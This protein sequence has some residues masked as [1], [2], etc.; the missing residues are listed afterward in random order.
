[1]NH[2]LNG[3]VYKTSFIHQNCV[4]LNFQK[5]NEPFNVQLTFEKSYFLISFPQRTPTQLKKLHCM[6]EGESVLQIDIIENERFIEITLETGIIILKFFQ[7]GGVYF[8]KSHNEIVQKFPYTLKNDFSF[9]KKY[10]KFDYETWHTN[11]DIKTF[12]PTLSKSEHNYLNK[13][14][15]FELDTIHQWEILE[16]LNQKL[17]KPQNFYFVEIEDDKV[18]SVTAE[19]KILAQSLSPMD[20]CQC[21]YRILQKEKFEKEKSKL[22]NDKQKLIN[23]IETSIFKLNDHLNTLNKLD[24]KL[25]GDLIITNLNQIKKGVNM[26]ECY[27]FENKKTLIKLNPKLT[28]IENAEKYYKKG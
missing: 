7:N 8:A 24:Y 26:F 3:C 1:M 20:L 11:R 15:F 2:H 18:V 4:F 9:S 5:Q 17:N 16:D 19:G 27:D 13:K 10:L 6:L 14:K 25:L 12:W 22:I 21:I 28:P 23:K